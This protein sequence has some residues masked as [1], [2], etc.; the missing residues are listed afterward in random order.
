MSK[1]RLSDAT[2][3]E[4]GVY[5]ILH[6]ATSVSRAHDNLFGEAQQ[7][8]L[9]KGEYVDVK[10]VVLWH[11]G[12][13]IRARVE[14]GDEKGGYHTCR[15]GWI[16]L[17]DI[18]TGKV[19]AEP[20]VCGVY[21]I[22]NSSVYIDSD[23]TCIF[24]QLKTGDYVDV[25]DV[26][27]RN[28]IIK[29]DIVY[30]DGNSGEI[31][32]H[33]FH[34]DT[35][36]AQPVAYG[37]HR[38]LDDVGVSGCYNDLSH[39]AKVAVLNKGD[40]VDVKDVVICGGH[41]RADI[42]CGDGKRGWIT[43]HNFCND[44]V[45]A[46]PVCLGVY[47][48]IHDTSIS[49]AHD[50]VSD[51]GGGN[52]VAIL[53]EGSYICV[54]RAVMRHSGERI[55]ANIE[56][57][58]GDKGWISLNNLRSG[59]VFAE[60]VALGMYRVSNERG[61]LVSTVFDKVSDN[62]QVAALNQGDYVE[63]KEV[64]LWHAG[65]RIRAYVDC[66]NGKSGWI[67]IH[68]FGTGRVFVTAVQAAPFSTR[69]FADSNYLHLYDQYPKKPQSEPGAAVLI[70]STLK[71]LGR[72]DDAEQ[73]RQHQAS[74]IGVAESAI[75]LWTT[76]QNNDSQ[77]S[78]PLFVTLNRILVHDDRDILEKGW[79]LF[80]RLATNFLNREETCFQE[81]T[82]VWRGSKVT[83]SQVAQFHVDLVIRPPMFVATTSNKE[84][85]KGFIGN[86]G[87]LISCVIPAGCRNAASVQALSIFQQEQEVLIPP[88][89]PF[90]IL[91]IEDGVI[92]TEL[93]DGFAEDL[94]ERALPI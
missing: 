90:R 77:G 43:L 7:S 94:K 56:C 53:R 12:N 78:I 65:G 61:A 20:V 34:N 79:M 2:G 5:K 36:F 16:S 38:V 39:D 88:Y 25:K 15:K 67:S 3:L 51:S 42:V 86:A 1:L 59:K 54:K 35:V 29:A 83:K 10:Q 37:V 28:G 81:E 64:V 69:V 17:C 63:L 71:S 23:A 76:N 73:Y 21:K 14:Y 80:V 62:V 85:A 87:Y 33:N 70:E 75:A 19:F 4:N 27:L 84:Q 13:C 24:D 68:N 92:Y 60:P 47:K 8:W 26:V 55:R 11:G 91:R 49:R 93:L 52:E 72:I 44:K 58:N 22:V 18:R 57:I 31:I 74:G 30:G 50:D 40:Y 48:V 9:N 66:G 82:V 89:S 32:L 45:F 6:D 41:T 46:E